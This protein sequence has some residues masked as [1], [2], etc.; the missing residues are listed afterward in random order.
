MKVCPEYQIDVRSF[1]PSSCFDH[2]P[3][4]IIRFDDRIEGEGEVAK[5]VFEFSRT[6]RLEQCGLRIKQ[7]FGLERGELRFVRHPEVL[8]ICPRDITGHVSRKS[9]ECYPSGALA[10]RAPEQT[11]CRWTHGEGLRVVGAGRDSKDRDIRRVATK[12]R[13]IVTYPLQGRHLIGD[14]IISGAGRPVGE[15][16][17]GI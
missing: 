16:R 10:D 15:H 14:T 13:D 1:T 17:T 12:A 5:C 11:A 7:L 2:G 3:G 6:D 9:E 4:L 8:E